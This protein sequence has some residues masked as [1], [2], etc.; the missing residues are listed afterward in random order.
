MSGIKICIIDDVRTVIDGIMKKIAWSEY[1]IEV[2]GTA[3]NG[4]EG[5]EL[6]RSKRP[7]IILT[8]I[9]MPMRS[10]IDMIRELKEEQGE[11]VKVIFFS[12][13]SDFAYA[14][15]SI[16][17]GAFDYLLKPFTI[18]QVVDVVLRAKEE[19]EAERIEQTDRL[20]LEQQV[21]ESLPYLRQEYLR[22]FIRH[23]DSLERTDEKWEV[24]GIDLR[25]NG[26]V[27]MCVQMDSL[28][29][30][31]SLM[32]HWEAELCRFAVQNILEETM[33]KQTKGVVFREHLNQYVVLLNTYDAMD[34]YDLAEKCRDNVMRYAKQY[35]SL[36][37][38]NFVEEISEISHSYEQAKTA[39]SYQFYFGSGCIISYSDIQSDG[40]IIPQY[41]LE[42]ETELLYCLRSGNWKGTSVLLDSIFE[43]CLRY[44]TPPEPEAVT[45]LF[46]GLVFSMYRV[47]AEK[48][49]EE[50]RKWLDERMKQIK[51]GHYQST[52]ELLQDV[53]E[54]GRTSCEWMQKRQN[55]DINQLIQQAKSYVGR[56]LGSD[57]NVQ[58][59]SNVVHLSP[60]YF[61]S[62]F[63]KYTGM[64]FMQYV[65]WARMERAKELLLEGRQVQDITY[66]LGY[67]D[68][69]YFTELFKKHA[70]LTPTEFR[71]KYEATE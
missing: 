36:G 7:H 58:E 26:F 59:C 65:T 48:V 19:I 51:R 43:E 2:V 29:D 3:A 64:T 40:S 23:D 54:F 5:L 46:F 71:S 28:S 16:R 55:N 34:I 66:E 56:R 57:L 70:G 20:V 39:L 31:K 10:G 8:D 41:A 60:S 42:K 37:I 67:K 35:I 49:D 52:V 44:P 22:L 4:E 17:L 6:I 62:L 45:N 63:K 53:Q 61:S 11:P 38:G 68:R 32:S 25:K 9:R 18:Q 15:E 1:G 30:H 47:I 24:L 14:Q 12:G 21:R 69:P 27:T 13:Y 50:Q 33:K